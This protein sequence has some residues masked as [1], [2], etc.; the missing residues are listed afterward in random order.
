MDTP[1][2]SNTLCRSCSKTG[3]ISPNKG[4]KLSEEVKSKMRLATRL[5][6]IEKIRSIRGNITPNYNK[7]ACDFFEGLNKNSEYKIQHAE[8]GGEYYIKELGYWLDGYDKNKNI[9]YEWYEKFHFRYGKLRERD[10][11]RK[12]DII[13][14]LKCKVVGY[15]DSGIEIFNESYREK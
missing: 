4:K 8:N 13:K 15:N 2:N 7:K 14:L 12:D 6:C 11:R 9:V 1:E 3:I 5:K 10:I